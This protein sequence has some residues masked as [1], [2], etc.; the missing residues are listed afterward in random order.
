[1]CLCSN[2]SEAKYF[3]NDKRLLFDPNNFSEFIDKWRELKNINI[4]SNE[5]INKAKI[6]RPIQLINQLRSDGYIL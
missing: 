4:D 5:L 2:I 3:I 6:F 1:M